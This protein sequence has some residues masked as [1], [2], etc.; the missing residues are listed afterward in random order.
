MTHNEPNWTMR[1]LQTLLRCCKE[2][3]PDVK[4]TT[5]VLS[6]LGVRG[7]D[8]IISEGVT[9]TWVYTW[10]GRVASALHTLGRTLS[11]LVPQPWWDGTRVVRAAAEATVRHVECPQGRSP[12]DPGSSALKASTE[13]PALPCNLRVTRDER[14]HSAGPALPPNQPWLHGSGWKRGD[15]CGGK[16]AQGGGAGEG[17]DATDREMLASDLWLPIQLKGLIPRGA[18]A[19]K[20]ASKRSPT[21]RHS[22]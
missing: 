13:S 1:G 6:H 10:Q 8:A 9:G 4:K 14:S 22:H 18:P 21:G 7:A 20:A 11:L 2:G 12:A 3:G 17:G 15:S 5:K 19:G 16:G